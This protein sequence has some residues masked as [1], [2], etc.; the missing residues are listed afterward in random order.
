[1]EGTFISNHE[2]K[3]N[4]VEKKNILNSITRFPQFGIVVVFALMVII[5]SLATKSFLTSGN[6]INVLRQASAQMVVSIGMTFVLI[7]GGIDLSVGSVA[8]LAGTMAAGFMVNN[9]FNTFAGILASLIIGIFAGVINGLIS[10]KLKIPPFIATLAMMSTA[11][12]ASLIYS[13]GYPISGLPDSALYLGRGY[14]LGTPVPVIFMIVAVILAWVTLSKTKFGRYVYA[15]GGNEEAARLSGIKINLVKTYVYAICGLSA[16]VTGVLLT[17]R[18]AS[19]QPTLGTGMEL[20]AIAAV[21]LG[22]TSLFGGRGYIFG[23][24]I[25]G[26]FLTVLGNG[27]NLLGVSSFWQMTARGV[28]LVIAVL[29]YEKTKK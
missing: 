9:G 19:S 4:S 21:V 27:F 25:G 28:I 26:M 11:R 16:A 3:G 22:G 12:G 20:D 18:L 1:M 2:L 14:V 15:I 24:I 29:L 6:I 13:G 8:C 23:T 7:L 10:S 17:T 5:L